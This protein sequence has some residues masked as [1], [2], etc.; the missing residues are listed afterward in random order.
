MALRLVY[1]IFIRL[2]GALALLLRSDVSKEAE[3]LVLRHQL[4]V[5]RRQVARPKPVGAEY[6]ATLCDL[7]VF[8]DQPTEPISSDDLDVGVDGVRQRSERAGLVQ[9]TVG[10]VGVE[11]VLILGEDLAQ[12]RGV[13]DQYSVEDLAAY[14]ADPA[15]HDGVHARCSGSGTHDPDAFGTEHFIEQRGELAVPVTNQKLERPGPLS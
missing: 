14:A 2:L 5:L 12:M 3:I 7:G 13:D 10:T 6:S 4:A 9:G 15:F 11:V 1:L 8:M